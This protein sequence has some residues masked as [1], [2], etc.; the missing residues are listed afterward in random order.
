MASFYP[1]TSELLTDRLRLRPWSPSDAEP[2]Q[3]SPLLSTRAADRTSAD[4]AHARCIDAVER[5][6]GWA[7]E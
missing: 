4:A 2:H 3:T 1:M 7:A 5:S 6:K